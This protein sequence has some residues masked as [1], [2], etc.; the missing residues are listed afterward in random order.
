MKE[1]KDYNMEDI[2][3]H[4]KLNGMNESAR[5][6]KSEYDA[7]RNIDV[8]EI[9]DNNPISEYEG[10]S[11]RLKKKIEVIIDS[12]R[13]EDGKNLEPNDRDEK[14]NLDEKDG[15]EHLTKDKEKEVKERDNNKEEKDL[16]EEDKSLEENKKDKDENEN[17]NKEEETP[18]KDEYLAMVNKLHKM[19]IVD[20]KDQLK[21]DDTQ[22]D[23]YF[24]M[25]MVLERKLNKQRAA[26]IKEY[27]ADELVYIENQNKKEEMKYEKTINKNME[28]ALTK[29]RHL[30]QKLDAIIDRMDV[31]QKGL[32]D[33][34]ISIE[35]Y[36][37]EINVLEK[38][39]V[40]T[41]WQINKLNPELLAEQQENMKFREKLERKVTP[42]RIDK[43]KRKDMTP[44]NKTKQSA[45][46]YNSK[47][48]EGVA[49]QEHK[50]IKKRIEIQID[51]KEQRLDKIRN[52]LRGINIETSEGKQKAEKLIIEYQSL[53]ASKAA[54]E[55]KYDN[56]EKNMKNGIQNYADINDFEK[57]REKNTTEFQENMEEVNLENQSAELVASWIDGVVRD[58][59]TPE[60]AQEL[61]DDMNEMAEETKEQTSQEQEKSDDNDVKVRTMNRKNN[62]PWG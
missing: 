31:L 21:K 24:I 53:V 48:Y 58:P 20:Y 57:E 35:E 33:E 28:I 44:E 54:D 6:L 5:N 2:L 49:E 12:M 41:L 4:L 32:E 25:M 29:L 23:R 62:K 52:E 45:M 22:V 30:E 59:E 27:G 18:K 40:D 60:Q 9:D 50:G 17:K 46:D 19:K 11:I 37:D 43:E 8:N 34:T 61:I 13:K 36:T 14:D 55:K 42:S 16:V 38:E 15:K 51:K 56:L 3:E 1:F 7:E 10:L 26:Y 39:K 47:K